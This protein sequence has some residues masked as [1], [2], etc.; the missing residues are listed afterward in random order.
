[1][2]R[3]ISV[4]FVKLHFAHTEFLTVQTKKFK[5]EEKNNNNLFFS[6]TTNSNMIKNLIFISSISLY[7]EEH[8]LQMGSRTFIPV[9]T[10]L[11][12][13]SPVDN[14]QLSTDE[15]PQVHH[16]NYLVLK[17]AI[18]SQ[19]QEEAAMLTRRRRVTDQGGM[20]AC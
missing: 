11:F 17:E 8:Q 12:P 19:Q 3:S 15:L 13:A 10:F 14:L 5:V 18:I 1:M 7:V 9:Q 6:S 2:L 20:L 4:L 16:G